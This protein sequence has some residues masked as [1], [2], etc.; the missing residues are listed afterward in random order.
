MQDNLYLVKVLG[1]F[2]RYQ[3]LENKSFE[4]QKTMKPIIMYF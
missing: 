3:F 4:L 2:K 1:N